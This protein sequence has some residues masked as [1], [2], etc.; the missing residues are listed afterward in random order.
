ME[1]EVEGAGPRGRPKKAWREIVEGDCWA[2]GLGM[3]DAV[4]RGG[5]M[6]WVGDD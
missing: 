1:Y 3:G 5:S 2:R 6:S 4:G